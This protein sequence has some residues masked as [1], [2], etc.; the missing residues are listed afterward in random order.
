MV[1]HGHARQSHGRGR[2]GSRY[3]YTRVDIGSSRIRSAVV[4]KYYDEARAEIEAGLPDGAFC[5]V[6]F[7]LKDLHPF[8]KGAVSS[9][10]SAMWRG[11][12]ADHDSTLVQ[13]YMLEHSNKISTPLPWQDGSLVRDNTTDTQLHLLVTAL[14]RKTHR[15]LFGEIAT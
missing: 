9:N 13:H 7:L 2:H 10:G 15:V 12:V 5:G 1:S 3:N 6:P 4:Y 14:H 8:M 11:N